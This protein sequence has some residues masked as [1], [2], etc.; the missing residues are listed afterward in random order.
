MTKTQVD[1][2]GDRIR[3]GSTSADDLRLL[4][5]YRDSFRPAYLRVARLLNERAG[6][7]V[8]GRTKSNIS[9]ER[10][11][12]RETSLRLSQMQ[13]IEGCRIVVAD[14]AM[15]EAYILTVE[16][17][18][19]ETRVLDRRE[20][21]SHG[22]RAVHLIVTIGGTAVEVQI[23]TSLQ[24]LWAQLCER[25]A[26]EVGDPDVK[27]GGGPATAREILST[28]SGH[29]AD[30]EKLEE[31]I[32]VIETNLLQNPDS[33]STAIRDQLPTARRE[34]EASKRQSMSILSE[35]VAVLERARMNRDANSS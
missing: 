14:V 22:Y 5:E 8:T 1:K 28:A 21:P 17:L 35:S 33:V 30:I 3:L 2:L 13:D 34:V 31:R 24:D 25:L 12:A 10:K 9:I 20:R 6:I 23:R 16:T 19:G 11:L 26:E 29:I 32:F 27:Y 4:S 7:E 18:F 15:Q